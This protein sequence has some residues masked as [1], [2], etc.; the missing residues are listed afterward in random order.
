MNSVLMYQATLDLLTPM[1][2]HLVSQS[3]APIIPI[4]TPSHLTIFQS[5]GHGFRM[6][7]NNKKNSNKKEKNNT[8]CKSALK[9]DNNN[10]NSDHEYD[11]D[12]GVDN[13]ND[14]SGDVDMTSTWPESFMA[15][16]KL[17]KLI[18]SVSGDDNNNNNNNDN[19]RN[20]DDHGR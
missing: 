17:N 10:D 18:V 14:G 12:D 2:P 15:W 1:I 4:K 5:G 11:N 6:G 20:I 3:D 13:N 7:K 16:L 9:A 19:S 8:K